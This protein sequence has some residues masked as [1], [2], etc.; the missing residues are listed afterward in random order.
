MPGDQFV[1]GMC[2]HPATHAIQVLSGR[3]VPVLIPLFPEFAIIEA[4]LSLAKDVV[5]AQALG[6]VVP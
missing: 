2:A 6:E 3:V 1:F 5:L 4:V